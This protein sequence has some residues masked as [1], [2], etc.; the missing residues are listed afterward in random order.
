MISTGGSLRTRC[1]K[2]SEYFTFSS[3][4]KDNTTNFAYFR[5]IGLS[6][7]L[8]WSLPGAICLSESDRTV[9]TLRC[10]HSD[11]T[12]YCRNSPTSGKCRLGF[13]FNPG[14]LSL[15]DSRTCI[16][17]LC[18]WLLRLLAMSSVSV[19]HCSAHPPPRR[20]KDPVKFQ[21]GRPWGIL[22]A[23]LSE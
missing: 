1:F 13:V 12:K 6:P 5:L 19:Y 4:I 17:T 9:R 22:L 3:H 10:H 8:N 18:W 16:P 7:R 2:D 15:M 11:C 14:I 20:R 21:G 23:D